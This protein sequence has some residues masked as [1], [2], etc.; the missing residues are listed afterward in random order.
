[1]LYKTYSTLFRWYLNIYEH[2]SAKQETRFPT[3]ILRVT[4]LT[5]KLTLSLSQTLNPD[6]YFKLLGGEFYDST[7][8]FIPWCHTLYFCEKW[9]RQIH[10]KHN[11]RHRLVETGGTWWWPKTLMYDPCKSWVNYVSKQLTEY[12]QSVSVTL[13]QQNSNVKQHAIKRSMTSPHSTLSC[14]RIT[15]NTARHSSK[16]ENTDSIK[17]DC[18]LKCQT[19]WQHDNDNDH[20]EITQKSCRNVRCPHSE[21][22]FIDWH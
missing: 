18:K 3:Q 7:V 16:H 5:L 4:N 6:R 17:T 22:D 1:M 10:N 8:K 12:C 15:W 9:H 11:N 14:T 20:K 21:D 13:Y 19:Q 2:P